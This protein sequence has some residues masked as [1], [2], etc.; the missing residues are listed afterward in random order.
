MR[1]VLVAVFT[2]GA[3]QPPEGRPLETAS[4]VRVWKAGHWG[5]SVA[6]WRF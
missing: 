3:P 4:V 2:R 1:A 5:G 6:Y